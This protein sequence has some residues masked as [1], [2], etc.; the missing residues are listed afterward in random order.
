MKKDKQLSGQHTPDFVVVIPA[1]FGSSRLPGKPL[2]DLGGMTMIERVV[3]QAQ[4]SAAKQVLV[5]TDDQRIASVLQQT[6][7]LQKSG[8]TVCMTR[9]DHNSGTDRLQ[10]VAQQQ[11]WSPQTIVVNVQGDEPLVPPEVINQVASNLAASSTAN[12]ATLC[13]RITTLDIFMDPNAVKVVFDQQGHA[14]YFSRA[15]IP[16]PRD[17]FRENRQVLPATLQAF[18]HIGI[19]AYRCELLH[20][21]VRWSP[22]LLEQTE[23]LEQL[24]AMS[25]GVKIHVA[26]ACRYVPPGVDT[27][28]DLQHVRQLLQ[29]SPQG[30]M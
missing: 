28:A 27:E 7:V 6:G 25:H 24:R 9:Q 8:V 23:S 30:V 29:A 12:M 4:H 2:L 14:L 11:G 1:R 17:A 16:W 10:E 19:Y 5:A 15:P 13:E 3:K 22:T 26:E 21:F 20:Q 18:R